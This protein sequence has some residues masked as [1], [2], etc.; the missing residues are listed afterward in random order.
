ML[1]VINNMYTGGGDTQVHALIKT[2]LVQRICAHI[3][4]NCT[5]SDRSI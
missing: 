3:C 5:F 4:W 1:A 2:T